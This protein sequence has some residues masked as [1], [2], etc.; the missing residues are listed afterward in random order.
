MVKD[1]DILAK[2]IVK[3]MQHNE[4]MKFT[5]EAKQKHFACKR[6][7]ICGD[8]FCWDKESKK[9]KSLRKVRDHDHRT[10]EYRGAAHAKCNLFYYSRRFLPVIFHNLRGYDSHL[11]LQ[12]AYSL[13]AKKLTAIPNNMEK[14]MT[15]RINDLKFIDSYQFMKASVETLTN[16]LKDKDPELNNFPNMKAHFKDKTALLCQKGV[17]PYEWVYRPYRFTP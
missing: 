12:A 9:Y 14:F 2:E 5:E 6:C 7:H 1:L 3:E 13:N 17:Y 10:G 4:K 11:I 16:N 15:F 8:K